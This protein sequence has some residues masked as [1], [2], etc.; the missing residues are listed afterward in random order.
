MLN[1]AVLGAWHVH[2]QDYAAE[3]LNNQNLHLSC[4]WDENPER[5]EAFATRFDIPYEANLNNVLT[6]AN[7]HTVIVT[8]STAAHVEVI[9][10]A[11]ASEKHIFTEKV[12]GITVQNCQDIFAAVDAHH[13]QLMVSLPR[14]VEP[15]YLFAEAALESGQLGQLTSIRCR[16]AH[17][18]AIPST[19]NPNGWLPEH[20]FDPLA[21]GGGALIDLGAHPIYLTNR[22]AGAVT[23]VSA[24][25]QQTF[26]RGVDDNSAVIVEY[27]SGALGILET[28]FVSEG[29]GFVLELHGTGGS[30]IIHED[31][32]HLRL[33]GHDWWSPPTLPKAL[34]SPMQQWV[35][36]ILDGTTPT[37]TRDDFMQLTVINEAAAKSSRDG[38]RVEL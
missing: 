32:T 38:R 3:V 10:A 25:L 11:A 16:M 15:Y 24:R 22:L 14:L 27:V 7:I 1:V 30:L 29:D 37:L 26:K 23:A 35:S 6:D 34:P 17:S 5:G 19:D 8:T 12:L 28:G 4:I 18:G 20:F 9:S 36:A 31:A 13:V 2:A 33:K 21:C